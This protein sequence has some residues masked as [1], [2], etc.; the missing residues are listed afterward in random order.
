MP[1]PASYEYCNV[2]ASSYSPSTVHVHN[3]RLSAFFRR[4]LLQ[5]AMSVFK[6]TLPESWPE[7]YFLTCLY[8]RGFIAVIDTEK[9]GVIPQWCTL[10]GYNV[11]YQPTTALVANNLL[12]EKTRYTIDKEC[13]LF[14]LC[15]DY[16]GIYDL[17]SYYADQM[18]LASEAMSINWL[19]SHLAFCF[20][21]TGKTAAESVKKMFDKVASGDPAVV[22]DKSLLNDDG[23][24]SWQYFS[25]NLKENY[26]AGQLLTDLRQ[27]EN[28]FDTDIGIPNSN[29]NKRER[30]ITDEVN[31][32]NVETA[33][34]CELWLES[35]KKACKRTR[36]LFGVDVSVE[37]RHDPTKG[38]VQNGTTGNIVNF[39][40]V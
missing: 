4:Y 5:K 28:A 27:I 32:N 40:V 19:N 35:L 9:F 23:T 10:T 15:P 39:G 3:T 17:I 6:W 7:N 34:K 20:G 33:S 24:P 25:Q 18:A 26:I 38:D 22:I 1:I 8:L 13:A 21:A 30:L 31:A 12:P 37:W 14:M 29:T 2:A 11:F 36:D 16:S